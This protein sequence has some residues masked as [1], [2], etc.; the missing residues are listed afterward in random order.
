MQIRCEAPGIWKVAK[1]DKMPDCEREWHRIQEECEFR[2]DV[3]II[4]HLIFKQLSVCRRAKI[5]AFA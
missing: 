3:F 2:I 4:F 1:W 5:W